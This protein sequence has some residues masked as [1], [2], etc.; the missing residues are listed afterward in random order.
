MNPLS[1]EVTGEGLMTR[2][3]HKKLDPKTNRVVVA[4]VAQRRHWWAT[5][6][7][8]NGFPLMAKAARRLLAM[9]TTACAAERNWSA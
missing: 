3:T 6:M 8:Q 7:A 2:L 5:Y 4:P 1:E 9:H